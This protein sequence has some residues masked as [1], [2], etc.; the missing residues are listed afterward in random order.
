L[1]SKSIS[2]PELNIHEPQE[3]VPSYASAHLDP[4]AN[5]KEQFEKE[6]LPFHQEWCANL[7][8]FRYHKRF[9]ENAAEIRGAYWQ[10][11]RLTTIQ[12][13]LYGE[14]LKTSKR[15]IDEEKLTLQARTEL[16]KNQSAPGH[17]MVFGKASD[18]TDDQLKQFE[19]H[20]LIHQD[21]TSQ[22]PNPSDLNAICRAIRVH[23]Q[24]MNTQGLNNNL[25]GQDPTPIQTQDT[26]EAIPQKN[27]IP[28][29]SDIYRTLIEQQ[30]LLTRTI[31]RE[32]EINK[33]EKMLMKEG[34]SLQSNNLREIQSFCAERLR[35]MNKKIQET[36]AF[37]QDMKTL[38]MT[39]QNQRGMEM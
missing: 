10:G 5:K 16:A 8:F 36:K 29:T 14:A 21:K 34:M 3:S 18:L 30:A 31:N 27:Q 12:G 4:F 22:L 1:A 24:I 6:R 7:G 33:E 2:I 25:E 15:K 13:R 35:R 20:V 39:R 38:E 23:S 28:T 32:K 9:P 17:I 37:N 19:Q 26:S 11:E